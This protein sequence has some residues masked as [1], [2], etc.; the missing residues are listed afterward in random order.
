MKANHDRAWQKQPTSQTYTVHQK[1]EIMKIYTGLRES[2]LDHML[3]SIREA[4]VANI[5]KNDNEIHETCRK[6]I[7]TAGRGTKFSP[8]GYHTVE[9]IPEKTNHDK[10]C[11]DITSDLS[12]D[13]FEL[14]SNGCR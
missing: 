9:K 12:G 14:N 7:N 10:N 8:S 4:L 2:V 13:D 1:R 11:S 5:G 3:R 6:K